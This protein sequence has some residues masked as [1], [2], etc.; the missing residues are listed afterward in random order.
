MPRQPRN[1]ESH[2]VYHVICRGNNRD[3]VLKYDT[4]KS[5][6][7]NILKKYR[8]RYDFEIYSFCIMSNHVHLLLK[9]RETSLSRIMQG[10]T[11]SFTQTMNRKYDQSGHIFEGRYFA[12]KCSTLGAIMKTIAYI[13]LNPVM[14]GISK[15]PDYPWSSHYAY[16]KRDVF[17]HGVKWIDNQKVMRQLNGN[18]KIAKKMYNNY[19][20]IFMNETYYPLI[21]D[22]DIIQEPLS[23]DHLIKK[24]KTMKRYSLIDQIIQKANKIYGSRIFGTEHGSKKNLKNSLIVHLQKAVILLNRKLGLISNAEFARRTKTARSKVIRVLNETFNTPEEK[25]IQNEIITLMEILSIE[26]NA[27]I[28]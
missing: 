1:L 11:Q 13:H 9:V 24:I 3:Y 10:I 14:A 15:T 8:E 19:I 22:T 26:F 16:A 18:V 5:I 25:N 7:L 4:D 20:K 28:E 2:M 17:K 12:S 23:L 21:L 6:Y 27:E